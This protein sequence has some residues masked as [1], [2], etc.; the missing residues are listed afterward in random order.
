MQYTSAL[1]QILFQL[2][3]WTGSIGCHLGPSHKEGGGGRS[4][5]GQMEE[6]DFHT[7]TR[8][9]KNAASAKLLV[10]SSRLFIIDSACHVV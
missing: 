1:V 3:V 6:D 8:E 10:R 5:H 2:L 9:L 7:G 4:E